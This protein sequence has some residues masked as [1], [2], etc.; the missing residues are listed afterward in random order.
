MKFRIQ[1]RNTEIYVTSKSSY[2]LWFTLGMPHLVN[3]KTQGYLCLWMPTDWILSIMVIDWLFDIY[4]PFSSSEIIKR[5]IKA[6]KIVSLTGSHKGLQETIQLVCIMTS[7]R[8]IY[9]CTG[10]I[11]LIKIVDYA[12][13]KK[14]ILSLMTM[15]L[16][17][18]DSIWRNM[19]MITFT[20]K[21]KNI[22]CKSACYIIEVDIF[23]FTKTIFS[24]L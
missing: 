18:S 4:M 1:N 20:F 2:I 15:G 8:T 17:T 3:S 22:V 23:T 5:A 24:I 9:R 12:H 10:R 7:R 19:N 14:K 6:L 21:P 11:T 16:M 13:R